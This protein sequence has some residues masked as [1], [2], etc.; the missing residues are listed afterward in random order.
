MRATSEEAAMSQGTGERTK[1]DHSGWRQIR[2]HA[3]VERP[4]EEVWPLLASASRS[5][6]GDD[7]G[8]TPGRASSEL[9]VWRGMDLSRE[10]RLHFGGVVCT[11]QWARMAIRWEDRRHPRLFPVLDAVLEVAPLAFERGEVTEVALTGWYRPPLGA[12]GG[13]A[14]RVAGR[15]VA[16]ESVAWFV[17]RVA[18]RI[19]EIIPAHT[20]RSA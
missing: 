4:Y 9:H 7:E 15:G 13:L 6:L 5:V 20:T 14:D 3:F 8:A 10:V 11:E 17:E 19:E 18:S 1:S 2:R 16:A 12:L